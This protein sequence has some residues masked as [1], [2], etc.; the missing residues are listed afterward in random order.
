MGV[1]E[2]RYGS[3]VIR[4]LLLICFVFP[5]VAHSKDGAEKLIIKIDA[6]KGVRMPPMVEALLLAMVGSLNFD[7]EGAVEFYGHREYTREEALTNFRTVLV[8]LDRL[9]GDIKPYTGPKI[10][11]LEEYV[12][13]VEPSRVYTGSLRGDLEELLRRIKAGELKPA[14]K[15]EGDHHFDNS[16]VA[17]QAAIFSSE[18]TKR[19]RTIL[20][21]LLGET[22]GNTNVATTVATGAASAIFGTA[23]G[24]E[25]LSKAADQ[26]DGGEKPEEAAST[27]SPAPAAAALELEPPSHLSGKD[28]H[29]WI[30]QKRAE[31]KKA[32]QV[33]AATPATEPQQ[34]YINIAVPALTAGS[35][36]SGLRGAV[37]LGKGWRELFKDPSAI[38]AFVRQLKDA[39]IEDLDMLLTQFHNRLGTEVLNR[40][41]NIGTT[42]SSSA[43]FRRYAETDPR[44]VG[45]IEV[46]FNDYPKGLP[47]SIIGD[48]VLD[49]LRVD[50]EKVSDYQALF[51][52]TRRFLPMA[53]QVFQTL[54]AEEGMHELEVIF[55]ALRDSG[56]EEPLDVVEGKVKVDPAKYPLSGMELTGKVGKLYQAVRGFFGMSGD[57]KKP[58]MTRVRRSNAAE[59]LQVEQVIL[60]RLSGKLANALRNPKDGAGPSARRIEQMVRMYFWSLMRE[61]QVE[62][63]VASQNEG[64]ARL[65]RS[66]PVKVEPYDNARLEI[67][68]PSTYQAAPGS[69][70]QVMDL[71]QDV[72]SFKDMKTFHPDLLPQVGKALVD[73]F[74]EESII[75]PMKN[76]LEKKKAGELGALQTAGKDETEEQKSARLFLEKYL[77]GFFHGDMHSENGLHSKP[78]AIDGTLVYFLKLID[79][80]LADYIPES[81]V[82]ELVQLSVGASYNSAAFIEEAIWNLRDPKMK[83][84][85][86]P[87][88][89]E[90]KR[91]MLKKLVKRQVARN[92][93]AGEFWG[94]AEWATLAWEKE[95]ID[96]PPVLF[97]LRQAFNTLRTTYIRDYGGTA[98]QFNAQLASYAVTHRDLFYEYMS[99]KKSK[100]HSGWWPIA[101]FAMKDCMSY[102]LR[103]GRPKATEDDDDV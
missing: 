85:Y 59:G 89:M 66:I 52:V 80:G 96:F 65:S 61:T 94:P 5:F 26:I 27:A 81:V 32:E 4:F 44:G 41:Y 97:F 19:A 60:T 17:T 92:Q 67:G 100:L 45:L 24:L 31:Q 75:K 103:F 18:S 23:L 2:Q 3:L 11:T 43:E 72:V 68:T 30:E 16:L 77:S 47:S 74:I 38:L 76:W 90:E 1:S 54:C 28:R 102:V 49:F 93:K 13:L 101:K 33:A 99:A 34:A 51:I 29:K 15:V 88:Q 36:A 91:A 70:V 56:I 95:V 86:K 57:Q 14:V 20:A 21:Q 82:A 42:V 78:Q 12:A 8:E 39:P 48:M 62:L 9:Y 84:S 50:G 37:K 22:S 71:V 64:A 6:A 10:K 83:D 79:Y 25:L 69:T 35:L 87:E 7:R 98:E 55:K 53:T 58:V 46:L 63:T 73:V 40:I